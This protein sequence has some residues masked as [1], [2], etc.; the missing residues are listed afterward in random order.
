MLEPHILKTGCEVEHRRPLPL[1]SGRAAVCSLSSAVEAR[2]HISSLLTAQ[3]G[4]QSHYSCFVRLEKAHQTPPYPALCG[5]AGVG[6]CHGDSW[7]GAVDGA[8]PSLCPVPHLAPHARG[9]STVSRTRSPSQIAAGS[10]EG[11]ADDT[12]SWWHWPFLALLEEG[13]G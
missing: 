13:L 2:G 5:T 9:D 12:Q 4:P 11:V 7:G 1:A 8:P 10:L 3:E 6:K